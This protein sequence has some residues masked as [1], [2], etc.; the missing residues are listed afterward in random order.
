MKNSFQILNLEPNAPRD[1]IKKAFRSLVKH[2]HPDSSSS[3]KDDSDKFQEV[4][5]AYQTLMQGFPAGSGSNGSAEPQSETQIFEDGR[6]RFEGVYD[7]GLNIFYCLKLSSAASK[8]GLKLAL[9]WKRE[10]AC[11]R[12]LGS[13][14]TF[15]PNLKG[16][17]LKRSL[18][19]RCRVTGVVNHNSILNIN[20]EPGGLESREIRLPGKGHYNPATS[21]RGD[22]IIEIE[23]EIDEI[24]IAVG[25]EEKEGRNGNFT[26]SKGYF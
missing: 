24:I 13:G 1:K 5:S 23:I 12:C 4:H 25:P 11:P 22:L 7:H 6:Y 20:L 26:S 16:G 17:H 10:D 8:T 21:V 15:N 9:P 2:Y 19:P 3:E 14:H 18:C